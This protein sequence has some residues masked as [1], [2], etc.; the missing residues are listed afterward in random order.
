MNYHTLQA[1][2]KVSLIITRREKCHLQ[3]DMLILK[4]AAA[5]LETGTVTLS[6]EQLNSACLSQ[7]VRGRCENEPSAPSYL[8]Q[9]PGIISPF[10]VLPGAIVFV[11]MVSQSHCNCIHFHSGGFITYHRLELEFALLRLITANDI[12]V[13]LGHDGRRCIL[14][15]QPKLNY[16]LKKIGRVGHF[17]NHLSFPL[18]FYMFSLFMF[19]I[20]LS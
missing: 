6:M 7:A 13:P 3:Y 8:H 19:I 9:K 17:I 1:P 4:S 14:H 10:F 11:L 15:R 5:W 16:Q 12:L 18:H 20:I 2:S